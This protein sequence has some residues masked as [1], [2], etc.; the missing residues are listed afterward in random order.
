MDL[1]NIDERAEV[2]RQK[3]KLLSINKDKKNKS[4]RSSNDNITS[5]SKNE[6]YNLVSPK[7]A[8]WGS[9]KISVSDKYFIN[10]PTDS[11]KPSK[12]QYKNYSS[13]DK[14]PSSSFSDPYSSL[15]NRDS[16][17]IGPVL[18]GNTTRTSRESTLVRLT[19]NS[20]KTKKQITP[21]P[22]NDM[23]DI[24]KNL[25]N[26]IEALSIEDES[27]NPPEEVKVKIDKKFSKLSKNLK[28]ELLPHQISGIK[29]L[30][31][32]ELL[33]QSNKGGL[34]CDDMGLGKT[35]QM[36][37][38]MS[39][40]KPTI[41]KLNDNS[42]ILKL[43]ETLLKKKTNA[44]NDHDD[45]NG[46]NF[47]PPVTKSKTTLIICPVALTQQWHDEILEKCIN[48]KPFIF[49]GPKRPTS[50]KE[51][52]DYDVIITTYS[53]VLSESTKLKGSLLYQTYWWRIILDEAH[54][55]KN[56]FAKSSIACRNLFTTRRWCVTGT[57]IQNN[58]GEL[59][60]LLLFLKVSKYSDKTIWQSEIG[61][62]FSSSSDELE[63]SLLN[64]QNELKELMIRRNKKILNFSKPTNDQNEDGESNGKKDFSKF[65]LPNKKIHKVKISFTPFEDKIYRSFEKKII[66]NLINGTEESVIEI[67]N[68]EDDMDTNNLQFKKK[69]T[70]KLRKQISSERASSPKLSSMSSKSLQD[71]PISSES[72]S[73]SSSSSSSL[74]LSK[75]S[76]SQE[77]FYVNNQYLDDYKD[78][79]EL[80]VNFMCALVYLL[81][82]RQLCCHW[83]LIMDFTPGGDDDD[84]GNGKKSVLL[85]DNIPGAEEDSI[86]TYDLGSFS[87]DP[88]KVEKAQEKGKQIKIYKKNN[89]DDDRFQDYI[90]SSKTNKLVEILLNDTTRKTIVFSQF[91]TMLDLIEI[92][93]NKNGIKFARYD[94]TMNKLAKDKSIETVK[95]DPDYQV[96]LC[97][98][99]CAS[100]GLNLVFANQ[101]VLF[102]KY[103]NPMIEDQA[104][105][106]VY[107]IGQKHDVDIYEFIMND[108]VEVRITDLQDKKR[109]LAKAITDNDEE[110]IQ[111]L[112]NPSSSKLTV[113]E[114]LKLFGLNQ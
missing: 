6:F 90:S 114:L 112:I 44:A 58:L 71:S 32:R 28:I 39:C 98:L 36:I 4:Y 88:V 57:P 14:N 97:S 96:L 76:S 95:K 41:K 10:E 53:T 38:L 72:S 42:D 77:G 105:D 30:I 43:N 26:S 85:T 66:E 89:L 9:K 15:Y 63:K 86:D 34:L 94:G 59:Q 33:V 48:L 93:L 13:N 27:K 1:T 52:L 29:F 79:N 110:S 91:T 81:R 19:P 47:S 5:I 21:P 111:K 101:V 100:V 31:K 46:I 92:D 45:E 87:K 69:G 75:S 2:L 23:E 84:G 3:L 82:L 56:P 18:Q 70:L 67:D 37:S 49:H 35:I 25:I 68:S 16:K 80:N 107:R 51:L 20:G 55:I 109:T 22:Q 102:D 113:T 74:S 24:T 61:S 60:A 65:K 83:N 73:P 17:D 12:E 7:D 8:S 78:N 108:S 104:S 11:N 99:K 62:K 106:R 50:L 54:M 64:L 103:W 40:Y